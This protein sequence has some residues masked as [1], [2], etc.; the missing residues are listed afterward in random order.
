MKLIKTLLVA[1]GLTF[2]NLALAVPISGFGAPSSDP[3]LLGATVIDF[4]SVAQAN[5]NVLA[6]SGVTIT[7]S[8]GSGTF[9][10]TAALSGQYNASGNNLQNG[11][12][13][14]SVFSFQFAGAV[15]AFGFNFGASNEDW[16]LQAFDSSATLLDSW[17]LPQTWFSNSGD[18][19]GIAANGITTV[20]LTQLT[21]VNDPATDHI[22]L[23]N[24]SFVSGD[25]VPEPGILA[26]LGVGLLAAFAR[27]R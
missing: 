14:A 25:V 2:A 17:V 11:T 12:Q 4:E 8:G 15:S 24:F 27:R 1:T 18:Y 9:D 10:I 19:F 20:V 6:T 7:G 5:Y 22:L 21:N 16:L 3:S 13:G 23:D 26:L